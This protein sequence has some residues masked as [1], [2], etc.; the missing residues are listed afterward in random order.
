MKRKYIYVLLSVLTLNAYSQKKE[1]ANWIFGFRAGLT[2]KDDGT[3]EQI[4]GGS[5]RAHEGSS[6]ISDAYGNLLFYTNGQSIWDRNHVI[7]PNSD[8]SQGKGLFGDPSSTQSSIIIPKKGSPNIYY[9]FT[10]DE[11]HHQNA[12][13]YPNLFSGQYANPAG[14]VPLDDNGFNNGF[15]YS[16]VDLSVIGANGSIG[17]VISRNNHLVTYN[18]SDSEEIRY[19]CSEKVTA[20]SNA[21]GSGYWVM[22]H[23]KDKFYAFEVTASGIN[24]PV[25]TQ[26]APLVPVSGY[27]RNAIGAMK[28]SPNGQKIAVAHQQKGTSTGNITLNGGV[29]LYDFNATTGRVSNAVTVSEGTTPYGLE[30]SQEGKKLYVSYEYYYEFGGIHQY[31]LLSSNIAS[32]DVQIG[33]DTNVGLQ[34]APNGKIY[35]AHYLSNVLGVIAH[36]DAD[37]RD[38]F[39]DPYGQFIYLYNMFSSSGFPQF[40]ASDLKRLSVITQQMEKIILYPNPVSDILHIK[41]PRL[42]S[43][44]KLQIL[45]NSGRILK[46]IDCNGFSDAAIDVS[47]LS[48]GLYHL[49]INMPEGDFT[50]KFIKQ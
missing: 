35:I 25:V 30:F 7:M 15:N 24:S 50:H 44:E 21:S 40:I 48:A 31:D 45:D 2:F 8:Y 37:G 32:S 4:D 22:T 5:I 1:A 38:C 49:N 6:C 39:Y 41:N 23:F 36:P 43:I 46:Q 12:A 3:V 28:F 42:I 47:G 18:P 19:K 13:V 20:V 14:N 26:I 33:A 9:V 16:I 17:D 10:V 27:R 34:L 29:Y 11:P